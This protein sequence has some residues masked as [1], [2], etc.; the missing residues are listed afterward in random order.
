MV[1]DLAH[2]NCPKNQGFGMG[3]VLLVGGALLGL[4]QLDER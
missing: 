2:K 3:K 4:A 1:K